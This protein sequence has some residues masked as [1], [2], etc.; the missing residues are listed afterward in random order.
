LQQQIKKMNLNGIETAMQWDVD[1]FEDLQRYQQ[2]K[3][4]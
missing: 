3:I 4:M 2:S 1:T